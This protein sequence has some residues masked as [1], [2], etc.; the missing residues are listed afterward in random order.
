MVIISLTA[1]AKSIC[2]GAEGFGPPPLLAFGLAEVGTEGFPGGFGATGFAAKGGAGFGLTATGGGGLPP[3]ELAGLEFAGVVSVDSCEATENF[4]HGV[5]E[6][7]EGAIP[8]NTETGLAA[9]SAAT[10]PT[11]TLGI[12]RRFGG[13]G[14][15]EVALGL[16]GTSSR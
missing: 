13:G 11:G 1:A 4:F 9:E 5:A 16:G 15:A 8:G 10:E 6:P 2:P 14:G 7:L 12:G 3:I